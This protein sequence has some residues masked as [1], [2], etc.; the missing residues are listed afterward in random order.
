MRKRYALPLILVF[1]FALLAASLVAAQGPRPRGKAMQRGPRTDMMFEVLE[2][3]E[4]QRKAIKT[5]RREAGKKK[6]QKR[7]DIVIARL[8]LQELME[9]DEPKRDKIH[10]QIKKIAAL[11]ADMR[12]LDVDQRLEVRNLLTPEQRQ[13]FEKMRR[14]GR[15]KD[16]EHLEHR[17]DREGREHRERGEHR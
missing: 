6:A 13:H 8:D 11:G 10:A 9:E 14:G 12:I 4:Q 17:K 5:L 16:R 7:A 3:D 1:C 2:L 15:R